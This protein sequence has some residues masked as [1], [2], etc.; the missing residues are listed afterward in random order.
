M[1]VFPVSTVGHAELFT[2]L[3]TTNVHAHQT[4]SAE[5]VR[6]VGFF[7]SSIFALVSVTVIKVICLL[8]A[9]FREGNGYEAWQTSK[10][11]RKL[12]R[13][14]LES[15]RPCTIFCFAFI[16]DGPLESDG[17][18]GEKK[19]KKNYASENVK[20]NNS[21]T[22]EGKEKN[23]SEGRS[24]CDFCLIHKICQCL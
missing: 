19:N 13:F 9:N 7:T 17:R 22:E 4:T 18:G 23:Y 21:C 2:K 5:T 10:E 24:N 15:P 1:K 6:T 16:R 20:K 11:Q 14:M 12:T 3:T 8:S